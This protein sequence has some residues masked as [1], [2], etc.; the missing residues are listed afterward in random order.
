MTGEPAFYAGKKE[1]DDYEDR[2]ATPQPRKV[3]CK[4]VRKSQ[5]RQILLSSSDTPKY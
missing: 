4:P 5:L 2:R 3:I 1:A